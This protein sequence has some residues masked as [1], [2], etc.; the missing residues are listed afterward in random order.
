MRIGTKLFIS[1]G[2][3]VVLLIITVVMVYR[4]TATIQHN[5]DEMYDHRVV[6]LTALAEISQL[7]ENTRVQMVTSVLNEDAEPVKTAEVNL[8]VIDNLITEYNE[9]ITYESE[10]AVFGLFQNS[11]YQFAEIVQDNIEL[12]RNGQFQQAE[13][14]LQR[15]GVPFSEASEQLSILIETNEQQSET[16][17]SES[18]R[19][20][21]LTITIS[22]V[23]TIIAVIVAI[24]YGFFQSRAIVKPIHQ[25]ASHTKKVA[26]GDLTTDPSRLTNR[27]DEIGILA[28]DF[29]EMIDK[30]RK[31]ISEVMESSEHVAAS[32][33]QLSASAEE[34]SEATNTITEAIQEVAS[35][36]E[37]QV[38]TAAS[39]NEE[40]SQVSG[41]LEIITNNIET[42]SHSSDTT[43]H[44]ALGGKKVID[45]AVEQMVSIQ[46]K[47]NDTSSYMNNLGEKSKEIEGIISL[48]TDIAEQTNLLALNAAIEAARAGEHGK[49]FTVV[50][51]EV[52]KLAE[53]SGESANKISLLIKDIQSEITQSIDSMGE[54]K[55]AVNDGINYVNKAGASFEEITSAISEVSTQIQEV[56]ASVQQITA[57]TEAVVKSTDSMSSTAQT[58]ASN[59]QNVAASAEE[60]NASMEEITASATT[61]SDLATRLQD[62][63]RTFKL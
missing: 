60:Q 34:T 21:E 61:L 7:A 40:V 39:V 13:L 18:L 2:A 17:Y 9:R 62:S 47:T 51:D 25:L 55:K 33:Q 23:T 35:G 44:K 36:A 57:S 59:T 56:S 29:Q 31:I 20:Y 42:V 1:Y 30:L 26:E 63:V 27:K 11:W 8:S 10:A 6:P 53:Q 48:I 50:A 49:G 14:G 41:G 52:R 16:L 37:Y 22:I 12:V 15:G 45:N 3:L 38:T 28:K 5:V 19:S 24:I 58:S 46:N 54:G 4:G 43:N 32:S